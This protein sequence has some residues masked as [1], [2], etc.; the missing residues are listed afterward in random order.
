MA[1]EEQFAFKI[2]IRKEPDAWV[3]HCLELNL[4]AVAQTAE[5]VESD[6]IDVIVA[7]VRYAI[8]NDNL[9][10]MYH[11]APP[12]VWRDFFKCTDRKE[13]S[14]R[15]DEAVFDDSWSLIPVIQANKCFYRQSS[16]V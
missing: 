4:V 8:E 11:P 7:H 10:H 16:H 12:H 15:R 3:A 2:L 13:E 14:Y 6:I 5:Q 9:E 1:R